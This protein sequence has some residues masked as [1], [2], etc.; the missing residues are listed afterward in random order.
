[1]GSVLESELGYA[2]V[3]FWSQSLDRNKDMVPVKGM[4]V[5]KVV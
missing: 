3:Q 5:L 1:M 4:G 2:C